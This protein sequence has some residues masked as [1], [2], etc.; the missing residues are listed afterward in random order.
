MLVPL[1]ALASEQSKPTESTMKKYKQFLDYAASQPDAIITYRA[2]DMV[3]VIHSNALYLN[4]PKARSHAGGHFFM[5]KSEEFPSNNGAVLNVAM[6][7]KNVM[8]SRAEEEL[9]VMFI[10]AKQAVHLQ[11]MLEELRHPQPPTSIQTDSTMTQGVV[12][13]KILPKVTKSMDVQL[14]WLRNREF[15][16]Q[17]CSYWRSGTKNFGDYSTNLLGQKF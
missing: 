13:N 6:L 10:N 5:S 15:R 1:S 16:E 17:F 14:H 8:S 7:I 2:I 3:L 4:E 9:G 12:M 11:R